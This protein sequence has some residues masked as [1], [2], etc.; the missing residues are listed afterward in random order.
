[1]RALTKARILWGLAAAMAL[2]AALAG[3]LTPGIYGRVVSNEVM[4]GVLSQ[5]AM[6]TAAAVA[7]LVLALRTGPDDARGQA[8]VLGIMGF[9]YYAYGVYSI[10]RIYTPLYLLYLAILGLSFFGLIYG[11]VTVAPLASRGIA[12]P[13]LVRAVS[14]AFLLLVPAMF[15]P[16]WIA[17]LLPL[18]RTGAEPEFFYSVYI[19]D[20]SFIMPA[21]LIVA[22]RVVRRDGLGLLLTPALFIVGFTLLAPLPIGELLKPRYGVAP[23]W[24]S[25]WLFLSL[26]TVFLILAVV[27]LLALRV[28][29]E[30]A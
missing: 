16:L 6:T 21:F 22:A 5:D 12:M 27:D 19:L 15:Y 26:A 4:P 30:P 3:V 25:F 13:R 7:A 29:R 23:D 10:E 2:I 24:F 8:V 9:L 20:L 11:V 28:G 14:V 18:M 17:R 1:M